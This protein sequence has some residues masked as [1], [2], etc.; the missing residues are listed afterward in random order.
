MVTWEARV[1]EE[2]WATLRQAY[3][4][5]SASVP[6]QMIEHFLTQDADDPELWRAVS[7]WHSAEALDE[8]RH[9]VATPGGQLVF[10]AAGVE[11]TR[12]IAEVVVHGTQ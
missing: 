7:V 3:A 11:T 4:Q 6:S 8:Y 2:A 12:S 9:S 1:P 10:R 5:V